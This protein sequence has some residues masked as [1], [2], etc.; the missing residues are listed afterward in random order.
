MIAI[1]Q[2]S[3]NQSIHKTATFT[4]LS[5]QSY[6]IHQN[7]YLTNFKNQN[8]LE[9]L[10]PEKNMARPSNNTRMGST[11]KGNF[12]ETIDTDWA[13]SFTTNS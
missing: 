11:M 13:N 9:R 7:Q 2:C 8:I 4:K 10:L 1:H 5:G 12:P 3:L 6:F